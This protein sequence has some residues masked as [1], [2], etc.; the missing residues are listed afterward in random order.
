MTEDIRLREGLS[1]HYK[2]QKNKYE[3]EIKPTY[4]KMAHDL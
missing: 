4:P 1:I 3:K 2:L